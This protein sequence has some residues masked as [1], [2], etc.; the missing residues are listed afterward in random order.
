MYDG[1]SRYGDFRLEDKQ[2]ANLSS[3]PLYGAPVSVPGRAH[4][5]SRPAEITPAT[6]EQYKVALVAFTMG[7]FKPSD[8]LNATQV[9]FNLIFS[10]LLG[11]CLE[12]RSPRNVVTLEKINSLRANAAAAAQAQAFS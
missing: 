12:H 4:D 5:N 9:S 11:T 7:T 6:S 2:W 1:R 10:I 3:M 8:D